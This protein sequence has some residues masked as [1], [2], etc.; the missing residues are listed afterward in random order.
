MGG[1]GIIAAITAFLQLFPTILELIKLFQKTP[2]E[3][4]EEM[5][6]RIHLAVKKAADTKGDTS[7]LEDIFK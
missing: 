2:K 6:K 3:K 7:D 1:V 4:R 5:Q